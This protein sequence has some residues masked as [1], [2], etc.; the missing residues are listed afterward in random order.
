MTMLPLHSDSSKR[1]L[2]FIN[3]LYLLSEL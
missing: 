3:L 2:G 1:Q